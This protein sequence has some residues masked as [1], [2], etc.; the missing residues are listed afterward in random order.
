MADTAQPARNADRTVLIVGCG[1]WGSS[2]ALALARRGYKHITVL[3]SHTLPSAISAANDINKI[4]D[5]GMPSQG[6]FE[7]G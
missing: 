4:V 2:T 6:V 3:D 5:Q 7:R 1:T